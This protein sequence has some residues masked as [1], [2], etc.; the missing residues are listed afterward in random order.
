MVNSNQTA[1]RQGLRFDSQN[2]HLQPV[3]HRTNSDNIRDGRGEE[4]PLQNPR[5]PEK[6]KSPALVNNRCHEQNLMLR[7]KRWSCRLSERASVIWGGWGSQ[8][9]SDDEPPPPVPRHRTD[10]K[11][12]ASTSDRNHVRLLDK[13]TKSYTCRELMCIVFLPCL[14]ICLLGIACSALVIYYQLG[15]EYEQE[16]STLSSEL[17]SAR[18]QTGVYMSSQKYQGLID[19]VNRQKIAIDNEKEAVRE[20]GSMLKKKTHE[21]NESTRKFNDLKETLDCTWTIIQKTGGSSLLKHLEAECKLSQRAHLLLAVNDEAA[22]DK[23]VV[24]QAEKRR[25]VPGVIGIPS[26]PQRHSHGHGH[27]ENTDRQHWLL[28]SNSQMSSESNEFQQFLA[29]EFTRMEQNI[30]DF[31]NQQDIFCNEFRRSLEDEVEKRH[32]DL[33]KLSS[34]LTKMLETQLKTVGKLSSLATDQLYAEQKWVT[35]YLKTARNEADKESSTMQKFLTEGIL[36]WLQQVDTSLRDQGNTLDLLQH[37]INSG[38]TAISGDRNNFLNSQKKMLMT[39]NNKVKA[40]S[41]LQLAELQSI[42]ER[43]EKVKQSESQFGVRFKEAKRKIDGLLSSLLSEYD[44]YSALVNKTSEATARNLAS[45]TSRTEQMT[46]LVNLAI[47][48]T[49]DENK[50]FQFKTESKEKLLHNEMIQKVEQSVTENKVINKNLDKVEIQTKQF[51]GERQ[52][53]WELHY[54]NQEIQLRKKADKNKE[55]LQKHQSQSQ[56]LHSLVRT[57]TNSLESVLET[58]RQSDSRK[59]AERQADLQ[60]QCKNMGTFTELLSSELHAR[61]S[62]LANYF[63]N[64]G[65]DEKDTSVKK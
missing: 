10:S 22:I 57:A 49:M 35:G 12:N 50:D 17:T 11:Y 51:I 7:A 52:G 60:A 36:I 21:L 9:G 15:K 2:S 27:M 37:N 40:L 47:S 48:Q 28:G 5:P 61:D 46:S 18:D 26:K 3:N 25:P 24:G 56:D 58:H 38:M 62:D 45:T 44:S 59:T 42:V 32:R 31:S 41:Q 23:K 6:L 55:L 53:A 39:A 33:A 14:L 20:L 13:R 8:T 34:S 4:D 54:S 64:S 43:E 63:F 29:T 65:R 1:V 19:Q 30:I 16:I